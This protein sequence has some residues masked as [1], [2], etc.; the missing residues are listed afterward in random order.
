MQYMLMEHF[1]ERVGFAG[2]YT[3]MTLATALVITALM[4]A[5]YPRQD[6]SFLW[7]S[8]TI[9]GLMALYVACGAGAYLLTALA[10]RDAGEATNPSLLEITYPLFIIAFTAIFLGALLI[11]VG[12]ALVLWSQEKG[13]GDL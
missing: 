1:F 12:C 6:W 13:N 4:F 5:A 8:W 2:P 11:V 9:G 7:Q 3:F 10:I